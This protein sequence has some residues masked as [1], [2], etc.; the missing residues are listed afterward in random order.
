MQYFQPF[1][2][3]FALTSF[4]QPHAHLI[5]MWFLPVSFALS[6]ARQHSSQAVPCVASRSRPCPAHGKHFCL[7]SNEPIR[8]L[9]NLWASGP[10]RTKGPLGFSRAI[11]ALLPGDC[12][13]ACLFTDSP[14]V[15]KA[16][17]SS[18]RSLEWRVLRECSGLLFPPSSPGC[19]EPRETVRGSNC[20]E[21][22]F[23]ARSNSCTAFARSA[24]S[25][26]SC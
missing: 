4:P 9:S 20:V 26:S 23:Q 3:A 13:E 15:C 24:A 1:A 12:R 2:A 6:A 8:Y 7:F 17:T 19:V 25:L 18:R 10:D 14:A 5:P 22:R 11:P 16:N 21:G